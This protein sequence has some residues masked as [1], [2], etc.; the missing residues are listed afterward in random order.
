MTRLPSSGSDPERGLS[1]L[2]AWAKVKAPIREF[3]FAPPRRWRFDFAWPVEGVAVE[4]EGGTW[5]GGRHTRPAAFERDA[6]KYNEAAIR[7]WAVLR[8]TPAMIDDG[9]A[10]AAI[11]RALS[12]HSPRASADTTLAALR[13]PEPPAQGTSRARPRS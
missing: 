12:T 2:L 7:G 8:V 5:V 9:R 10:V 11:E 1:T 13:T 3:A 6:E 4:V